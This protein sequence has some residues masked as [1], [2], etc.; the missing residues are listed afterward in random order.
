MLPLGVETSDVAWKTDAL[1]RH[2]FKMDLKSS[3]DGWNAATA[4]ES[5]FNQNSD[6]AINS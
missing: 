4:L 6:A 1:I 5:Y 3:G 2:G